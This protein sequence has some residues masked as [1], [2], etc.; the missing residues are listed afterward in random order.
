MSTSVFDRIDS[1]FDPARPHLSLREWMAALFGCAG[2]FGFMMLGIAGYTG[3]DA[4]SSIVM[5]CA[6][7]IV[8]LMAVYG[9]LFIVPMEVQD[10]ET[11]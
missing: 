11:N 7:F 10:H 9:L 3:L 2:S 4:V 6:A 5:I 1:I 8:F